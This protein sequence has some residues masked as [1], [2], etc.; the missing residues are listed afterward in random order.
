VKIKIHGLLAVH[1]PE[2][3]GQWVV[4]I[5]AVGRLQFSTRDNRLER[6]NP[7]QAKAVFSHSPDFSTDSDDF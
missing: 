4:S 5:F 7:W 2:S 3:Y 1:T 6:Q